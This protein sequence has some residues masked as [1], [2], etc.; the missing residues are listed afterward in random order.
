M[1][2]TLL[3]MA[4]LLSASAFAAEKESCH[5]EFK[6]E[7]NPFLELATIPFKVVAA[8]S[9]FPRCAIDNFPVDKEKR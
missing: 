3:A 9:H 8:F 4:F 7:S 6:R 5:T 1:K 2:K